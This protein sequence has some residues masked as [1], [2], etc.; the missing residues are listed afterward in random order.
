MVLPANADISGYDSLV[1][2]VYF[3]TVEKSQRSEYVAMERNLSLFI[4]YANKI[5]EIKNVT[6]GHEKLINN[7]ITAYNAITQNASDY[8]VNQEDWNKMVANVQQAKKDLVAFKLSKAVQAV[9]DVQA[10]IDALDATFSVDNLPALKEVAKQTGI[11][12]AFVL[13]AAVVLLGIDKLCEFLT[14]FLF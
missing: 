2:E 3:G 13:V 9:R 14:G 10:S 7:A 12:L 6:L 4:E 11:V 8:G 5:S 1:Y